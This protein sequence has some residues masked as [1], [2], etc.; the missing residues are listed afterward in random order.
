MNKYRMKPDNGEEY[1]LETEEELLKKR[2]VGRNKVKV[3]A[4]FSRVSKLDGSIVYETLL[5][6]RPKLVKEGVGCQRTW[7]MKCD[8][9]GINPDQYLEQKQADA[10]IGFNIDYDSEGRAIFTSQQQ[11]KRYCEATGFYDR[12][13]GHS[14]ARRLSPR[15]RDNLG[16][17]QLP[18][19]ETP[20]YA[21]L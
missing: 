6:I 18:Q 9:L 16:Y 15:E 12:N 4:R 7:P 2:I 10:E 17:E 1:I 20:D 21:D 3:G 19:P 5:E 11:Y 14:G 13:G 8:A